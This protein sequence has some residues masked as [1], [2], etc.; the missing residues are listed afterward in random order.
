MN[1]SSHARDIVQACGVQRAASKRGGV[2]RAVSKTTLGAEECQQEG[3]MSQGVS[4]R[5]CD[6]PRSVSKMM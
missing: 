1:F 6:E 5:G 3:V 2:Q 4:A